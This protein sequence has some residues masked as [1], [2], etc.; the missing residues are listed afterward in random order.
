MYMYMYMYVCVCM[1]I[2]FV[3]SKETYF[4][5]FLIFTYFLN[6]YNFFCIF[7]IQLCPHFYMYVC[8]YVY[9]IFF[10]K[11]NIFLYFSNSYLIISLFIC[12]FSNYYFK[13][14]ITI[15]YSNLDKVTYIDIIVSYIQGCPRNDIT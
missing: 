8:V 11:N 3:F 12:I 7:K 6:I 1:F 9:V 4:G 2:S 14:F 5:I 13:I 15:L 10:F